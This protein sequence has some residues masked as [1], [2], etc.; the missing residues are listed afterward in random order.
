M[1]NAGYRCAESASDVRQIGLRIGGR[2][3]SG[4]QSTPALDD[5]ALN[6]TEC[7]EAELAEYE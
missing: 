5:V 1:G 2:K 4:C 3:W 7:N 6:V